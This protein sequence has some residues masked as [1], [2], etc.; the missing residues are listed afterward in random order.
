M[1][2][3]VFVGPSLPPALVRSAF[4]G[5]V[6]PPIRRGQLD[7]LVRS[8]NP[9]LAVGIVDGRFLQDLAVSPKEVLRALDSGIAI[10][11]ASSMG[12]L[13][14]VECAP[15]GAVGVGRIYEMFRSRA[16]E[17]DDEVALTYDPDTLRATSEP[18]VNIRVAMDHAVTTG[19]LS[20]ATAELAVATAGALYFPDRTYRNVAR[21]LAGRL[22]RPE[23]DAY[24]RFVRS[25]ECP[26]QK[27]DDALTL[28]DTMNMAHA[29]RVG[30]SAGA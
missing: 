26:D 17:A 15:Y 2:D 28:L 13:R 23:L 24:D 21:L 25:P 11:G 7:Q 22:P 9:P 5:V 10:Y 12:A 18:M 1:H 19:A 14:A 8:A 3:V 6:E 29:R 30:V 4:S 16:L 27:R 20:A